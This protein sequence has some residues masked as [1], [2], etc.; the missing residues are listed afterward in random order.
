MTS[1]LVKQV[2]TQMR[3]LKR[4]LKTYDEMQLEYLKDK[5][6]DAFIN[7]LSV[8]T[9]RAIVSGDQSAKKKVQREL[10][11]FYKRQGLK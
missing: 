10:E 8:D 7:S 5:L 1:E 4:S 3:Q 11:E 6:R 2:K 9:L